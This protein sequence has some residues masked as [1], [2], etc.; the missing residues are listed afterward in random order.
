M[1]EVIAVARQPLYRIEGGSDGPLADL[2]GQQAVPH[3]GQELVD[4]VEF[5][6]LA[7]PHDEVQIVVLGTPDGITG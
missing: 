2:G 6:A 4:V 3:G 5:D 1:V 7:G